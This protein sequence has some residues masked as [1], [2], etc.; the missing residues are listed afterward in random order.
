MLFIWVLGIFVQFVTFEQHKKAILKDILRVN[1]KKRKYVISVN[2]VTKNM[3]THQ[4]S[5]IILSQSMKEKHMLV[6]FVSIN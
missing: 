1:M 4:V 3:Q 5:D 6:I 2:F